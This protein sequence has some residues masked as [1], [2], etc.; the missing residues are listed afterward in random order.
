[1]DERV[2]A[3][4]IPF[5]KPVSAPVKAPATTQMAGFERLS[6]ALASLSQAMAEQRSAVAAWRS[7]VTDLADHVQAMGDGL[8]NS[9]LTTARPGLKTY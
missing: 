1:M 9:P 6:A 4:I 8:S 5:P 7:A 3:E 2:T